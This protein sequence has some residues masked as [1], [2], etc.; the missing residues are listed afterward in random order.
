MSS[1][2]GKIFLPPRYSRSRKRLSSRNSGDVRSSLRWAIQLSSSVSIS[3]CSRRFCSSLSLATHASLSNGPPIREGALEAV[4]AEAPA[5]ALGAPK[6]DVS[7]PC[8][9]GFL[10]SPVGCAAAFRLSVDMAAVD[11]RETRRQQAGSRARGRARATRQAERATGAILKDFVK[12][13]WNLGTVYGKD[14]IGP[15]IGPK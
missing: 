6:K 11:E 15:Q 4:P 12:T 7:V 2:G 13:T 10:A 5:A 14:T 8:C 1:L 9:L 3:S